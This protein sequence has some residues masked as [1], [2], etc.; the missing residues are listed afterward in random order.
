LRQQDPSHRGVL[1][2][3]ACLPKSGAARRRSISASY[4]VAG[5]Q[6]LARSIPL[7]KRVME[8]AALP[9]VALAVPLAVDCRSADNWDEAH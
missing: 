6:S 2:Y 4:T 8:E 5:P 1:P 9:D 7:I 3:K